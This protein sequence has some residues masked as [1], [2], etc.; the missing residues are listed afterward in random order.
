MSGL[1]RDKEDAIR[2]LSVM[3]VPEEKKG[4]CMRCSITIT[5]RDLSS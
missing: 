1:K 5:M 3:A 2:H 4:V